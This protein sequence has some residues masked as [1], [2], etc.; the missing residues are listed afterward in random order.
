MADK[1]LK[2]EVPICVKDGRGKSFKVDDQWFPAGQHLER[3]DTDVIVKNFFGVNNRVSDVSRYHIGTEGR[4]VHDDNRHRI[5][6]D[7]YIV[8][9]CNHPEQAISHCDIYGSELEQLL[10]Q[11]QQ[12]RNIVLLLESPHEEEY[13]NDEKVYDIASPQVPARG[14]TG[15]HIDQ[16]LGTVLSGIRDRHIAAGFNEAELI[17]PG[18]HIIISNPIQFQTSLHAIHEKSLQQDNGKWARLRNY[19]WRTL[20]AEPHIQR[21]FRERLLTY[22]PSLIINACT[23]AWGC[24]GND[25]KRLVN[26][27]VHD[28][29]ELRNVPRYETY[30]PALKWNRR[31]CGTIC[32]RRIHPQ[33]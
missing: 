33:P 12:V 8:P 21:C 15:R 30:H 26:D 4:C 13:T 11:Q 16:C 25:P 17:V 32:I 9:H 31:D 7:R 3:T 19:V 23:G 24:G 14:A 27:F 28:L 29:A 22:R 6:D 5:S 20:W 18:R 10:E 2:L 1:T